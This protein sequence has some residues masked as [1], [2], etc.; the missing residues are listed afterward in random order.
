MA[1]NPNF[2]LHQEKDNDFA[3]PG[4]IFT[5]SSVLNHDHR[6]VLILSLY[7]FDPSNFCAVIQFILIWEDSL[8]ITI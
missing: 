4:V 1:T 3:Y 8:E 6:N 7:Y 2:K 5:G